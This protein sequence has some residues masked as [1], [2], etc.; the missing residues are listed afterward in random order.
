MRLFIPAC[1]TLSRRCLKRAR[2]RR[3]YDAET[4]RGRRVHRHRFVYAKQPTTELERCTLKNNL[5]M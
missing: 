2:G 3:G 4:A 1:L 5:H